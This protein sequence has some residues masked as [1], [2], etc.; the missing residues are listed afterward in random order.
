MHEKSAIIL[1]FMIV[2]MIMMVMLSLRGGGEGSR[3]GLIIDNHIDNI[4]M[5]IKSNAQP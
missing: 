3:R 2:N 5:I 4:E 1:I